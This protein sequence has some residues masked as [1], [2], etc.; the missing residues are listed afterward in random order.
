MGKRVLSP[1]FY[2][3]N[4][5]FLLSRGVGMLLGRGHWVLQRQPAAHGSCPLRALDV[6]RWST[7]LT[8]NPKGRP[9]P[10]AGF[11]LAL[12]RE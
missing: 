12:K 1:S 9:L 10:Q 7:I 8:S 6:G 4:R 3:A 2:M 5:H 11:E